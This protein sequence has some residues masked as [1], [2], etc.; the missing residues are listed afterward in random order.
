MS[1]QKR[2]TRRQLQTK[3]GKL[4][5]ESEMESALEILANDPNMDEPL[6]LTRLTNIAK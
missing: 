1:D 5:A 4:I 6:R 3:V 2:L